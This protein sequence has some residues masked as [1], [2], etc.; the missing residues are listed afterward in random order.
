M[1][2][3]DAL[4]TP[5]EQERLFDHTFLHSE[6]LEEQYATLEQQH[7]TAAFGMWVFLATE[8]MFFGTLFIAVA[9]YRAVAPQAVEAA[10][11]HLNWLIGGINTLVLLVSSLM[12][13]LAVHFA[14]LDD[15]RRVYRF[16][17]ATAMLG[18]LFLCLKGVEYYIDYRESLIPGWK[19]DTDKWLAPKSAGGETEKG[20]TSDQIGYV[21]IFLVLYWTMTGLHALHVT[22]GIG[23]VLTMAVLSSRGHFSSSYY[24]P[25]DVTGLYWHFVDLVW[26]FLLPT[27]YLLGTH[28]L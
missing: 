4:F 12:M 8:V 18:V 22:I 17:L 19:F 25:I 1:S 7:E 28:T 3:K 23:V 13:V 10:S 5:D 21:Q 14:K 16:L 27:L 11:V 20:L 9:A 15:Q 24:T 2:L 6:P 26:I